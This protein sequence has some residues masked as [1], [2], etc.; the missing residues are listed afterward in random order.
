M[1]LHCRKISMR[2]ARVAIVNNEGRNFARFRGV[3]DHHDIQGEGG[4]GGGGGEDSRGMEE[5]RN[6]GAVL[7][8]L[9]YNI[10]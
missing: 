7:D 2:F 8:E 9:P 3:T 1:D 4:G 6:L 5:E 10:G